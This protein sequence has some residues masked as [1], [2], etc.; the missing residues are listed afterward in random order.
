MKRMTKVSLL[1]VSMVTIICLTPATSMAEEY[2]PNGLPYV[3]S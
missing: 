2:Q 1:I 3:H